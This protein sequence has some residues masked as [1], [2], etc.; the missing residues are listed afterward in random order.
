M[1]IS[2]PPPHANYEPIPSTSQN[3][4]CVSDLPDSAS[5]EQLLCDCNYTPKPRSEAELVV[6][7][8]ENKAKSSYRLDREPQPYFVPNPDSPITKI[9][10]RREYPIGVIFEL[11]KRNLRRV[12]DTLRIVESYGLNDVAMR[13]FWRIFRRKAYACFEELQEVC[14]EA[15]PCPCG[16]M[17]SY[18][19]FLFSRL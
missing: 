18:E 4:P 16:I 8:S 5:H 19:D 3:N 15:A 2:Q 14:V 6:L 7:D 13:K 1:S 12:F 11:V 9:K 17:R 10:S